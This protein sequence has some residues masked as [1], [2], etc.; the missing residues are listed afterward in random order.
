[1][2]FYNIN[3]NGELI[4]IADIDFIENAI[5]LIDDTDTSTIYIWVGQEVSFKKRVMIDEISK[6][7]E[8]ER[9]NLAKVLIVEQNKEYG[10]FLA[11]M[12][13]LK[14]GMKPGITTERRPEFQLEEPT[15]RGKSVEVEILQAEEE[16]NLEKWLIQ[17]NQYRKL[18]PET[19][20]KEP[21]LAEKSEEIE[22]REEPEALE[23]ENFE[24]TVRDGAYYLS[25][26]NYT[27]NELCWF[28]AEKIQ[29]INLR[30]PSIR[31]IMEKAEEVFNSSST[32]DELCWLNAEMDY[33]INT[34]FIEKEKGIFY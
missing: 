30:M 28:L 10:S 1:M 26:K 5:Y 25:L 2:L 27:Y 32:Y 22:E 20:K 17:I 18:K 31:D 8:K 14:I 29:K 9:G 16:T 33:L 15:G 24:S 11:M 6:E 21:E 3:D 4:N 12:E 19:V 7:L 13:D 34:K 23:E